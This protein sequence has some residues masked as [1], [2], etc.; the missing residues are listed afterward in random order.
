MT[1][2]DFLD[3]AFPAADEAACLRSHGPIALPSDASAQRLLDR[4][5][6]KFGEYFTGER[7]RFDLPLAPAGTEFQRRVW[8]A[9][10]QIAYGATASY[11]EIGRQIGLTPA[12]SR[13][14]GAANGANPIPILIPCH[15]VVGADG[16]L[17]GY[18]GGLVRKQYLLALE[19]SSL[20]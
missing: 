3:R 13:A 2:L 11:A 1:G 14:V 16:S 9:V 12:A 20:F 5:A 19:G 15:R 18:S 7:E 17:T 4:V 10:A 8:H 6:G